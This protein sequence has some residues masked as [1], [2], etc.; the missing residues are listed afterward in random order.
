MKKPIPK[1]HKGILLFLVLSALLVLFSMTASAMANTSVAPEKEIS[2][3]LEQLLSQAKADYKPAAAPLSPFTSYGYYNAGTD[4]YFTSHTSE[5]TYSYYSGY[6]VPV[7]AVFKNADLAPN[8]ECYFGVYDVVNKEYVDVYF[9]GVLGMVQDE[10]SL[11]ID[12]SGLT[13]STGRYTIDAF[14]YDATPGIEDMDIYD[15]IGLTVKTISTPVISSAKSTGESSVKVTWNALT[16]VTGYRVYKATS[17]TGTYSYVGSTSS[18]SYNFTGLTTGKTYYFKVRAYCSGGATAKYG[19]LSAYKYCKPMPAVPE[20]TAVSNSYNSVKLSWPKINLTSYYQIYRA[21]SATGTYTYVKSVGASTYSWTNTGLVTGKTYYYKVRSVHTELSGA[22]FYSS[23]CSY[24]AVKPIPSTPKISAAL[25][26]NNTSIKVSWSAVS[27][28][29]VY[30]IYRSTSL[31]G[32]YSYMAS[33]AGSATSWTNTSLPGNSSYYYKVRAYHLESGV[34]IYSSFSTPKF[35]DTLGTTTITANPGPDGT[36]VVIAWNNKRP[37]QG[38]Y[39]FE[40]YRVNP[41]ASLTWLN[42]SD[43]TISSF[44]DTGLQPLTSYTY[45]VREFHYE[46]STKVYAPFSNLATTTTSVVLTAPEL[47]LD[48]LVYDTSGATPVPGAQFH[49]TAVENAAGYVIESY[50]YKTENDFHT[51]ATVGADVTQYT[52]WGIN[53]VDGIYVYRVYAYYGTLGTSDYV[54]G[55]LSND[56]TFLSVHY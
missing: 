7:S 47:T 41:N 28:A 29:T 6:Q 52:Q 38:D 23:F 37:Y 3:N 8:I 36:S 40:V 16:R 44:V 9:L 51:L 42:P 55:V 54:H 15:E 46:G 2:T 24:K 49:W 30:Q 33:V 10:G 27:G 1:R 26:S 19:S 18:S 56:W 22:K 45:K 48:G 5:S 35:H 13:V 32:T 25:G 4:V 21:T 50:D 12:T 11:Y 34:K 39:G 31:S 14:I 20:V 43:Y 17:A 53:D